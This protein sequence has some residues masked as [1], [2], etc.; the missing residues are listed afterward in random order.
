MSMTNRDRAAAADLAVAAFVARTGGA[1]DPKVQHIADLLADLK[2]LCDREGFSFEAAL[3]HGHG[4]YNA[5]CEEEGRL[6]PKG[7]R[8]AYWAAM[9]HAERRQPRTVRK[10][11]RA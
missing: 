9:R 8:R 11:V 3:A 10:A 2:H 5:E 6:N 1:H 4:H 7:K